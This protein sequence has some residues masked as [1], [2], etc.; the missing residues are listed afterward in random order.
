MHTLLMGGVQ[1][2]RGEVGN[3][4]DECSAIGGYRERLLS[5]LFPTLARLS[6]RQC[7]TKRLRMQHDDYNS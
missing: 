3:W 1:V 5:K 4:G 2:G 6:P 7:T